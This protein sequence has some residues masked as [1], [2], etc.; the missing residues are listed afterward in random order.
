MLRGAP[1]NT[2]K[3]QARE[4]RP[5]MVSAVKYCG[6]CSVSAIGGSTVSDMV[7]PLELKRTHFISD[8]ERCREQFWS[9]G[10][11]FTNSSG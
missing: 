8:T 9:L 1:V 7:A 3:K 11:G 5:S 4:S 10:K 2:G 6:L